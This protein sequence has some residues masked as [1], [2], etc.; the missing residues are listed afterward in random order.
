MPKNYA[1]FVDNQSQIEPLAIQIEKGIPEKYFGGLTSKRGAIFSNTEIER[2]I[3]EEE[4]HD[5]RGLAA[6][7]LQPLRSLSSGERKKALLE[8]VLNQ[9]PDFLVLVNPFDNLDNASQKKLRQKLEA[10]SES[11]QLIQLLNRVEDVLPNTDMLLA[12]SKGEFI[13]IQ[14]VEALKELVKKDYSNSL[15]GIP[16]PLEE[17]EFNVSEKLVEFKNVTVSYGQRCILNKINWIVRKNEFWQLLGPNG[18]GKTTLLTLITGDNHKGYRQD[19]TLFG[20]KKGSGESVWD[21]K[22]HIGYF[23][24]SMIDQFR[25]YHTLIHMVVSGLHDSVGLYQEPTDAELRLGIS[26]LKIIRLE[27]KKNIQFRELS[28]GEKRLVMLA[29][30]MIKHPPLLILD[31][32]TAGLD[33]RNAGF[34]V[35]LVNRIADKSTSAIVFVSHRREKNLNPKLVLELLPSVNGSS[36]VVKK[37]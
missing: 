11:I 21:I 7:R 29:R 2:F 9:N 28:H 22:E 15:K 27:H 33:D 35:D 18:S 4:Q 30:A 16:P 36:G 5:I 12:L 25:G 19:L 10:I 17:N 14:N 34:F 31:E 6:K 23:T 37:L 1:I 13:P 3:W 20:R 24:P 26:W 8:H 32:P